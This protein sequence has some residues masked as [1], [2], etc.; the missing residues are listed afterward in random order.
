MAKIRV[1]R[2]DEAHLTSLRTG[3]DSSTWVR[4]TDVPNM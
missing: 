2:I 3:E 1:E 4:D